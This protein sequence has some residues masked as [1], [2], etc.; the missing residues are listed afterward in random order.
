M[1]VERRNISPQQL[2]KE[3][4]EVLLSSAHQA[5]LE[6]GF[7]A[8]SVDYIAKMSGVS[9]STI[10]RHFA[11]KDAIFEAVNLRIAE[12]QGREITTFKLDIKQPAK[13]LRK[14][15]HHIYAIDTKPE[16]L[17]SFR[18]F[19]SEAGRKPELIDRIRARGITKVLSLT[20]IFFQQLIEQKKIMHPD[21]ELAASTFYVLARGKFRP[22]LGRG[23]DQ[24]KERKRL[25]IDID[26]FLKGIGLV[27]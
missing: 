24:K 17:E 16:Y 20:T 19:I 1:Q 2:S 11:N 13:C 3:R 15:A 14:F 26:I 7:G 22:L 23:A 8:C 5:F 6:K 25:D 9:K 10:Y 12:Q 18:L 21:A 4:L 27:D